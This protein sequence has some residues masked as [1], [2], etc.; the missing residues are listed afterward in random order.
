MI[1][2][3]ARL[4][5]RL[6]AIIQLAQQVGDHPL[7]DLIT[8]RPQRTHDVAQTAADP[9]QRRHRIAADRVLDQRL[10]RR[11]QVRLMDNG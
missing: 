8:I 2:A 7:A 3:L 6:T 10:Q 9:A 5:V 1:G 4:A 11:G